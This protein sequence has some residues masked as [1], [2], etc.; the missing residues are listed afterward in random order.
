MAGDLVAAKAAF[1]DAI[2][3]PTTE[4]SAQAHYHLGVLLMNDGGD[5][6]TVEKHFITALNLGLDA[7]KEIVDILGEYHLA[8][9][10]S[11]NRV[12]RREYEKS[13]E[14]DSRS[15]GVL[16]GASFSDKSIFQ[17]SQ[18]NPASKSETLSILE[19]GAASYD[20]QKLPDGEEMGEN[21]QPGNL[22]KTRRSQH[23]II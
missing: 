12:K 20:G 23:A 1:K 19:Q 14:K 7:T 4:F 2:D 16:G 17:K 9:L 11:T 8:V 22:P 3:R 13:L 6:E 15:G 18:E 10:K 5:N 21:V